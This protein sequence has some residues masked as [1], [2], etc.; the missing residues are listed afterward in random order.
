[1]AALLDAGAEPLELW[2][3]LLCVVGCHSFMGGA[4][5]T[6]AEPLYVDEEPS[7]VWEELTCVMGGATRCG[8]RS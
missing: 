6:L 3:G 5:F 4:I 8:G 2:V 1:M 7:G